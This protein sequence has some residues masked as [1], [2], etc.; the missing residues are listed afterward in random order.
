[1]FCTR[2]FALQ[3]ITK[4]SS[5][6]FIACS[7]CNGR[8]GSCKQL[9]P[10]FRCIV[11]FLRCCGIGFWAEVGGVKFRE[12]ISSWRTKPPSVRMTVISLSYEIRK[13]KRCGFHDTSGRVC[14]PPLSAIHP[15]GYEEISS[16]RH[17]RFDHKK[18]HSI[19]SVKSFQTPVIRQLP[20]VKL[21]IFFFW[22][23]F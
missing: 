1:M 13:T 23:V 22:V 5:D 12:S 15:D 21:I 20:V 16:N 6:D 10:I 3:N 18:R 14:T 7:L 17:Y 2:A 9:Y 19:C 4:P 8:S 11:F